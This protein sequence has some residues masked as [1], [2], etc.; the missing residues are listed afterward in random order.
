M[1]TRERRVHHGMGFD[2][3]T[4]QDSWF[5][6]LADRGA[7]GAALGHPQAV[8]EACIAIDELLGSD[9]GCAVAC[10]ESQREGWHR[11]LDRLAECIAAA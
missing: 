10:Y 1:S 7:I 9:L 5:W 6:K 2:L 11:A 4:G 3:W 8:S